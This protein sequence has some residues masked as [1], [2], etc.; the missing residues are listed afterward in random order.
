MNIRVG[1]Y[2]LYEGHL[3][4]LIENRNEVPVLEEEVGYNV[5]YMAN[6]ELS[7]KGFDRHPFEKM[8]CRAFKCV[9]IS[10]ALFINTYGMYRG[11]KVKVYEYKKDPT[12]IHITINDIANLSLNG[13][14]D[15]G[16]Y[17]IKEIQLIELDKLWEERTSSQFNFPMP[18]TI[19]VYKEIEIPRN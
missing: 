18:T 12:L 8:Y 9:E 11:V 1:N 14:E 16:S 13:F 2:T 15:M 19:D 10:N 6:E 5:C 17:F 4:K 7:L 3:C